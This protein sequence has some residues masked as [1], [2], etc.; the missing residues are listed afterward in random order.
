MVIEVDTNTLKKLGISAHEYIILRMMLDNNYVLLNEYIKSSKTESRWRDNLTKLSQLGYVVVNDYN[1]NN[2]NPQTVAISASLRDKFSFKTD[3]FFD[4]YNRFPVK[5]VR[6]DGRQVYLRKNYDYCN[7]LYNTVIRANPSKH[8]SIVNALEAE[9]KDR[10]LNGTMQYMK[11]LA[12]WIS[13][14]SWEDYEEKVGPTSSENIE[15]YGTDVE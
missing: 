1:V 13:D 9:K 7:T 14:K 15:M 8:D 2:I 5:V 12:K 11:T 3:P 4:L 10:E 6:P